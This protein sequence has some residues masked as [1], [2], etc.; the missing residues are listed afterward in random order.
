MSSALL[1]LLV[2]VRMRSSSHNTEFTG[3]MCGIPHFRCHN[4]YSRKR[5]CR[6]SNLQRILG[7]DAS[8]MIDMYSM[9]DGERGGAKD[10]R[11][12]RTATTVKVTDYCRF[13]ASVNNSLH[14][15]R[16]VFERLRDE[17]TG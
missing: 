17:P 2:T 8:E 9:V 5:E 13:E 11:S 3:P 1:L 10:D 14:R 6:N 7:A 15:G 12:R 16:L 4:T